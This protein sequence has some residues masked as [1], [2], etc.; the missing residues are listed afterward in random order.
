M[1]LFDFCINFLLLLSTN[2]RTFSG[3]KIIGVTYRLTIL[4]V[5]SPNLRVGRAAFLA[6]PWGRTVP[7][8]SLARSPL[9]HRWGALCH[10]LLLRLPLSFSDSEPSCSPLHED[11]G[12]HTAPSDVAQDNLPISGTFLLITSAVSFAVGGKTSQVPESKTSFSLGAHHS[13]YHTSYCFAFMGRKQN[14]WEW[15]HSCPAPNTCFTW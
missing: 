1:F 4:E 6:G 14:D 9:P 12:D 11:P 3:L 13:V 8:V 15:R 10:P 5:R 2:Y 7:R